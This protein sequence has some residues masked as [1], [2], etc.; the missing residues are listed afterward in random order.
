M[1]NKMQPGSAQVRATE[2]WQGAGIVP[3]QDDGFIVKSVAGRTTVSPTVRE[4]DFNSSPISGKEG[5]ALVGEPDGSLGARIGKRAPFRIALDV[6]Y[7]SSER[8]EAEVEFIVND[9][10][11]SRYGRGYT[12]SSGKLTVNYWAGPVA[13]L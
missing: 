5:Y 13:E 9:D 6:R 11:D 3:R 1:S 7:K 12:D 2:K 8:G 10:L 4:V